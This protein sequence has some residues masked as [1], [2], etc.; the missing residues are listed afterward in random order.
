M[1]GESRIKEITGE[2]R[3]DELLLKQMETELQNPIISVR[4]VERDPEGNLFNDASQIEVRPIEGVILPKRQDY[5]KE[6]RPASLQELASLDKEMMASKNR[7]MKELTAGAR[8]RAKFASLRKWK[9]KAAAPKGHLPKAGTTVAGVITPKSVTRGDTPSPDGDESWDRSME[10]RDSLIRLGTLR[11]QMVEELREGL[12]Q[13]G[14][15][16]PQEE[17][18][19]V[20]EEWLTHLDDSFKEKCDDKQQLLQKIA[21]SSRKTGDGLV[22]NALFTFRGR[23]DRLD[24]QIASLDENRRILSHQISLQ[25]DEVLLPRISQVVEHIIQPTEK[26][27]QQ[28]LTDIRSRSDEMRRDTERGASPLP[29]ERSALLDKYWVANEKLLST[30]DQKR[31]IWC[32]TPD[33]EQGS[34]W[35]PLR[36]YL[37]DRLSYL[38]GKAYVLREKGQD[39]SIREKPGTQTEHLDR[40][41]AGVER[42]IV[43]VK[44]RIDKMETLCRRAISHTETA[45]AKLR[46]DRA[47]LA[48]EMI[49]HHTFD[50]SNKGEQASKLRLL[51]A[52][53]T[54]REKKLA[55]LKRIDKMETPCKGTISHTETALAELRR[56][57]A[58]LACEMIMHDTF[59]PSNKGEQASK[60]RPLSAKITDREK[61]AGNPETH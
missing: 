8:A 30:R 16:K 25:Q 11:L 52:K 28:K 42:E 17:K 3:R 56:D 50:P 59:H 29:E 2:L 18:K 4:I 24:Q 44:E 1:I 55:T 36:T 38:E 31:S 14:W 20:L 10:A 34:Q 61:E 46:R 45:L 9:E 32:L 58:E 26:G 43:A 39:P 51:S 12:L 57:S 19:K 33:R 6:A 7:L 60:L 48:C 13:E 27:L 37:R 40:Q 47:E 54:D 35:T 23:I 21:S 22:E 53:I 41:R 49:M 15:P 5:D